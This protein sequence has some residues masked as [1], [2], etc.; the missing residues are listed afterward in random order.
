MKGIRME[1]E[2]D[3]WIKLASSDVDV[4]AARICYGEER[5]ELNGQVVA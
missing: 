4:E 1:R 5:G 3:K 2:I